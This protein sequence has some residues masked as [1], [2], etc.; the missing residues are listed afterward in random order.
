MRDIEN[1][2]R[3][4]KRTIATLIGRRAATYE[5][6]LLI[7]ASYVALVAMVLA[8]VAP[9]PALIAFVTLPFAVQAVRLAVRTTNPRALNF[10]ILRTAMLHTRFGLLLAAGL[11]AGL[12]IR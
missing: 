8:G 7:A 5:Y 4:S 9:W 10:V 1:D 6:V 11:A 3:H 2:R 12:L